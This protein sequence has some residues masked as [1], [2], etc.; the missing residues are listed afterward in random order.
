MPDTLNL[1]H[2]RHWISWFGMAVLR[3]IG[4]LPFPV[5]YALS[6]VLG[7]ILY[8]I[9]PSRAHV[10]LVN[11]KLCF[12]DMSDTK[13]KQMARQHFRL[14]VCSLLS[15]GSIWWSRPSR[16]RRLVRI[17]GIENLRSAQQ[18]GYNVIFLAPHFA[19]L[20]SGG[21]RLSMDRK[22]SS[23]YQIHPNPVFD[24]LMLQARSRV[25]AIADGR[26]IGR[27]WRPH[28]ADDSPPAM[29]ANTYSKWFLEF[30]F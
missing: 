28:S 22:M 9:I 17:K 5:I 1:R 13:R 16:L 8:R 24:R 19:A 30:I 15:I 14:L 11:L 3:L 21:M 25:N 27:S 23:M 12:S 6:A 29:D 4:C 26:I 2:P 20:D 10:T 18:D 7:E